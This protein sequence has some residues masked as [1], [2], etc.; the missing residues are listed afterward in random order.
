MVYQDYLKLVKQSSG[1]YEITELV[2]RIILDSAIRIGTCQLFVQSST[3]SLLICDKSDESI[4]SDTPEYLAKLAPDSD[5]A[6]ARIDQSMD[7]VPNNMRPAI[8][9]TSLCLPVHNSRAAIG[10]WQGVYLWEN[11][12]TPS[13][14]MITLTI[15]GE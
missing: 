11:N 12:S 2:N 10:V 9:Q 7:A 8:M 1:T 14:L 6:S 5:E 13:E 4:R 3:A 15:M